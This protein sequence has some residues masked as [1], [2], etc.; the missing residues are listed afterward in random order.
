[1]TT[2]TAEDRTEV[3]DNELGATRAVEDRVGEASLVVLPRPSGDGLQAWVRG[4]FVELADPARGHAFTPTPNDLLVSAIAS[5][6]AWSARAF[7]VFRSLDDNVAVSARWS[8]QGPSL[9]DVDVDLRVTVVNLSE[10]ERDVLH[11]HLEAAVPPHVARRQIDLV[12][13]SRRT[14]VRPPGN[15]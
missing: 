1:M 2:I 15:E 9:G 3:S 8:T 4:R 5:S 12:L 6:L 11:E 7:L 14:A 13:D 10:A